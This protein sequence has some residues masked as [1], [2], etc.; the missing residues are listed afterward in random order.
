MDIADHDAI[1]TAQI[2]EN[3]RFDF[4]LGRACQALKNS[5]VF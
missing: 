3:A 2:C 4:S 1:T 5:H